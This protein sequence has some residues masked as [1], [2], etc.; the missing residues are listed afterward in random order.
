MKTILSEG[1]ID[2][3]NYKFGYTVNCVLEK[4]DNIE[5]VFSRG[6]LPYTGDINNS[7][8]VYYM[9]RSIRINLNHYERLSE[10]KRIIKNV[11]SKFNI[12]FELQEKKTFNH[13][14]DFKD[15]CINA[16]MIIFCGL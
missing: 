7:K 6:F 2:Y 15:F 10:N 9:A 1:N 3:K 16:L 13:D 12:K 5:K 11:K 4:T 8:E 14:K